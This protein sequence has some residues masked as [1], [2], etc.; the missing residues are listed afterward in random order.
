MDVNLSV[1]VPNHEEKS[2]VRES[3][4][5]GKLQRNLSLS[6]KWASDKAMAIEYLRR[7]RVKEL[8]T[9]LQLCES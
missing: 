9:I 2:D 8:Y 5:G 1:E 3:A 7:Q 6:A 4:M